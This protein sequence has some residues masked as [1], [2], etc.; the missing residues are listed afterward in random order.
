MNVV[1]IAEAKTPQRPEGFNIIGTGAIFEDLPPIT[2]LCQSLRIAPGAPTLFAGYGYSGKSA[3]AQALAI[4]VASG[5]PL[6]GKYSCGQGNVL[7]LDYEQGGR[8]SRERYHRIAYAEGISVADLQRRGTLEL[9]VIPSRGLDKDIL[10]TLG[11]GRT[12]VLVDSWRAAHRGVDENSSEV[13]A[14]LDAMGCASEITGCAFVVLHHAKKKGKDDPEGEKYSIRG[15]GGFFDGPQTVFVLDGEEQGRPV[16][17]CLKERLTGKEKW[18]FVLSIS[19][20]DQRQ[21]LLIRDEGM[22]ENAEKPSFEDQ[23][24]KILKFLVDHP[25]GVAGIEL[26]AEKVS[27]GEKR[28][29]ALV[30]SLETQSSVLRVRAKGVRGNAWRIFHASHAPDATPF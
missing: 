22:P 5:C 16:V 10:S 29:A 3:A 8:L 26:L 12:L 20:M 25:E 24:A 28:T 7:H 27:I 15:S 17:T 30:S 11:E 4:S 18:S 1:P 23:S 21:G 14:T 19:D 2:W 13:R 9:G 6:W